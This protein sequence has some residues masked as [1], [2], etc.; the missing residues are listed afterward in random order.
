MAHKPNK[1]QK[2]KKKLAER[3]KK[4][5][6]EVTPYEGNKYRVPPYLDFLMAAEMGI[7]EADVISDR[8]ITDRD[9]KHHLEELVR[10]LRGERRRKVEGEGEEKALEHVV[11]A[12]I[13]DHW[14]SKRDSVMFRPT[15]SDL[16]GVLRTIIDSLNVRTHMTPGGRGYLDY[17]EGFLGELGF[18]ARKASPEEL[19]NLEVVE[20]PD[21]ANLWEAGSQ[22]IVDGDPTARPGFLRLAS[23]C[24]EEGKLDMVRDVFLDLQDETT[25]P[26][27]IQQLRNA[28][29]RICGST[30][31][32][33]E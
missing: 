5:G 24:V 15:D 29:R 12:R 25:D 21:E 31:T 30:W 27:L 13:R 14:Q 1:D 7:H 2:R 6:S 8:E 32:S 19:E 18:T 17:I 22:W 9:V 16:A 11:I 23:K 26:D 3:K 28:Q 33:P 4:A 10:E 20:D